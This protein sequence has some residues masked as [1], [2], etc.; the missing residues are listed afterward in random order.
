MLIAVLSLGTLALSQAD[1]VS[2]LLKISDEMVQTAARLRGLEPKAPIQ[3]GVK[4]RDEIAAFLNE[5]VK[6]EY[7]QG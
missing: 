6:E 1:N 3:K 7:N 4:N 2:D 5:R